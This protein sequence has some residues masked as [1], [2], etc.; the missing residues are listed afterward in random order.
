M[1]KRIAINGMGRI[2]RLAFR[3]AW[4]HPDLQIVAVNDRSGDGTTH[5]HLLEFDSVHGHWA[6]PIEGSVD[7]LLVDG[8]HIHVSMIDTPAALPWS[9]DN[10]DIVLECTGKHLTPEKL[11]PYFDN[12]I[13]KLVVSAPVK[14]PAA[15]NLVMAVNDQLYDPSQ[16]HLLTAASCTTNCLAPV[17]KVL[18]EGIGINHGAIT[19]IH[20][21]TNTQVIVDAPQKDLRRSRSALNSLIPTTTGSAT[22]IGII[23]P[24]LAGKLN[25]H[26]VRVPLLNASLT[27][28]VF[29][30]TRDTSVDEVNSLFA[31]AAAGP[32]TGILGFE[33]RPLVSADYVNDPRSAIVDGPSTMVV[34][35]RQ[36]KVFAWYDNEWGYSCRMVDL[37]AKISRLM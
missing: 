28:C 24:E 6:R 9:A 12:G 13:A 20:D 23:Y 36:V 32:L 34:N 3:A 11:Q 14:D 15:L 37:V 8:Q 31:A 19:T 16:H 18:H 7:A 4:N 25:G 17:V 21:V 29:E 33:S 2:G 1:P 22:A 5:A 27:D 26:A 30:M 10:V 35:N